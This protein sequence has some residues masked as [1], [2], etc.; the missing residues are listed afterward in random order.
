MQNL[1]EKGKQL[2]ERF[3]LMATIMDEFG[4][5]EDFEGEGRNELGD[6]VSALHTIRDDYKGDGSDLQDWLGGHYFG[7]EDKE[8]EL[9]KP[10]L[11]I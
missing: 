8:F 4:I 7:T 9:L 5:E 11:N 3:I 2:V 10:Y 6:I 1:N